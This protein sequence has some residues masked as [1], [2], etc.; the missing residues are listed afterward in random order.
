MR[1]AWLVVLVL[2]C[3]SSKVPTYDDA[4]KAQIAKVATCKPF[5]QNRTGSIKDSYT[6]DGE[7]VQLLVNVTTRER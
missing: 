2:G 5:P 3:G 6:C 1:H 4:V 7:G